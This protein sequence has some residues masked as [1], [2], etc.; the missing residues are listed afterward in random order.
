MHARGL[1]LP[2]TPYKIIF[3][4]FY[5]ISNHSTNTILY[6]A[7]Q[8]S[9][10]AGP[11]VEARHD[12]NIED[13]LK[14]LNLNSNEQKLNSIFFLFFIAVTSCMKNESFQNNE[15][16]SF[17]YSLMFFHFMFCS[18]RIEPEPNVHLHV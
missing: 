8:T 17:H 1:S 16:Q 2:H 9:H 7:A 12:Q 5:H 13:I 15:K 14:E 11:S 6:T 3:F 18:H 4:N 10:G